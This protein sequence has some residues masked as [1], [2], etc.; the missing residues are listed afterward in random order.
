MEDLTR[1]GAKTALQQISGTTRAPT[2]SFVI[3]AYNEET[4]LAATL[5][6]LQAAAKMLG[7]PHEIVVVD[8]ASTD[9]TAEVAQEHGARVI[10]VAHRQIAATRNAGAQAAI[11]DFLVFIDADTLVDGPVVQAALE[12][13]RAGAVGGGSR[14]RFGGPLPLWGNL[15]VLALR[16]VYRLGRL[17]SGCFLFCTRQAFDAVGGFD[18]RMYAAEEATMSLR[19]QRQGRFVILRESVVTSGRKLRTHSLW[20]ILHVLGRVILWPRGSGRRDGL[21]IWYGDRRP[22]PQPSNVGG[23]SLI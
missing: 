14:F 19:L 16:P 21:D 22:D 23:K 15:L 3:P 2:I 18:E 12:A 17:A 5:E 10:Q 4:V 20:E 9:R 8:D 11:G 1:V 6:S 13:L 7:E